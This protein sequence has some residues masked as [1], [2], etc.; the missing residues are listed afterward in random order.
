MKTVGLQLT[1][2][3]AASLTDCI[4]K[5][6]SSHKQC[7]KRRAKSFMD[8]TSYNKALQANFIPFNFMENSYTN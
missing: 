2:I 4:L 7:Q 5:V 6:D 3:P 1:S 8:H